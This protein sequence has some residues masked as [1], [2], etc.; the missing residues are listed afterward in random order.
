MLIGACCA[1]LSTTLPCFAADDV[2]AFK[3]LTTRLLGSQA[4]Q[5]KGELLPGAKDRFEVESQGGKIVIRG[6]NANS[7]A[8]GLNHYLRYHVKTNISWYVNNPVQL[9]KAL[10]PVTTK[11]ARDARCENRFFLNYCTFGY[12]MP[13]WQWR[14][15]EH[16]I[17]WM[18]LNGVTM[19]LAITGQEAIWYKV[20][21]DFGLTDDQIRSYFT[22]PAHLPWHRMANLDYWGGPLPH[23]WLDHQL[24]L[25]KKIVAR[26]R[27]L[28]MT[29]VLPAFAG[30]VPAAIKSKYPDA[31]ISKLGFWGGF[32]DKYRSHFLDPLDPLFTK[33]QKA[34]LEEQTKLFGT[35]HIYG[36]DPF[37]E[38]TPPSWE[39]EYLAKVGKT[40]Y[41]SMAAVDPQ[42]QWLQMTWVFYFDRKH[43]TDE[44][45]QA[46]VRSVPQDKMILLDYY[47][48]NQEVWKMTEKFFGQPYLWCYLGN[49]GGNSMLVGNLAEVEKRIE[50]TFTNGGDKV[51]GIGSTLESF[52]CN[53]VMYEYLFEKAWTTGPTDLAKWMADYGASRDGDTPAVRQAWES[54][55]E[56]V[57]VTPAKLGQGTLTNARPWFKGQGHWTTNPGIKYSNKDLLGILEKL[58]SSPLPG[59]D[60]YRHDV[61]NLCRQLLGNHFLKMR[62]QFTAAYDKQDIAGAEKIAN[63]MRELLRDL[64]TLLATRDDFMLG[65]WITDARAFG[66]D[67]AEK[68][69]Y[70]QNARNLLTTWGEDGQSLNDYANRMWAGLI[71]T[72]YLPRWDL[73]FN[74]SLAALRANRTLD[75][76]EFNK[77]LIE[78]EGKWVRTSAPQSAKPQ[79]DSVEI[80]KRLTA[81]YRQ[82]ILSQP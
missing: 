59:R 30:H 54:L 62:D 36:T 61:V 33:I 34:F 26:E 75:Q 28:N 18:A 67:A 7:M 65:K 43:W 8:V 63:E 45:I 70:E 38:I 6:N 66:K 78:M 41:D 80:T 73:F 29:P 11:V 58:L 56:K 20:W 47:C 25:Q 24:A 44:R 60:S 82:L 10:P 71:G 17:D 53:P 72:H 76:K 46:M 2:A 9:P 21:K 50:N 31:K 68:D 69:Y 5:V 52:D 55:F 51:W 3:G 4:S 48:E 35:D 42:A 23:S 22:G 12:T 1:T 49:F 32:H 15:W 19:P 64:D 74:E 57:Y 40:I 16:L 77:K 37:N 39:P 81:K 79:G 27:E 13:W 14:D